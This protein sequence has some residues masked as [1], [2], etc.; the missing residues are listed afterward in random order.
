MVGRV[1]VGETT[2]CMS[3]GKHANAI[4]TEIA[5]EILKKLSA[6]GVSALSVI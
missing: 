6:G 2:H 4:P 5:I 1:S 3:L